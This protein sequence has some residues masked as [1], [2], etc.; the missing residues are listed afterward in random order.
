MNLAGTHFIFD[1]VPSRKYNLIFAS[2]EEQRYDNLYGAVNGKFVYNKSSNKRY[3]I[4]D[5]YNE[6]AMVFNVEIVTTLD[7]AIELGE[8]REIQRWLFGSRQFKKLYIDPNCDNFGETYEIADGEIKHMFMNC[9][10]T[11]PRKLEYFGGVVGFSCTIETDSYMLW[12]DKTTYDFVVNIQDYRNIYVDSDIEDYTYPFISI[13][14]N[15]YD[16]GYMVMKNFSDNSTGGGWFEIRKIKDNTH[17]YINTEFKTLYVTD[18]EQLP[19]YTAYN[20][21]RL[22]SGD[23]NIE[24]VTDGTL[25][26]HLEWNNRRFM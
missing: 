22:I 12:Q 3:L 10:F 4:G 5:S 25:T 14:Y 23:N 11:N 20:F 18:S 7:R 1:D 17:M 15:G 26:V 8:L 6:S 13:E 21:P 2:V 19:T 16:N 9:R 24:I